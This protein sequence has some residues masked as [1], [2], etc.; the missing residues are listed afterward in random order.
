MGL[1]RILGLAILVAGV[2]LLLFGIN[3]THSINEKL[4]GAVQ[5]RYSDSTI[6]YLIGGVAG[7]IIGAGL[8]FRRRR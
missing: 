1:K 3:S 4:V 6:W 8:A 7:I 2:I 5:G